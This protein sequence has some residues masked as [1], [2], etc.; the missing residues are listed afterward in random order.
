L[1]KKFDGIW[2]PDNNL[3]FQKCQDFSKNDDLFNSFK[4]DPIF[5]IV[6]GNDVRTKEISDICFDYIN[7]NH[8]YLFDKIIKFKEN[9]IYGSPNLY[10]Y[11]K[12]GKISP[13]TLY[14]MFILSRVIENFG[15]ISNFSICEIGSGYGGQAKIFMD[16]GIKKYT[17]ID[18]KDTLL[19]AKKYLG[20]FKYDNISY[21]QADSIEIEKYDLVIS[22]WCLSEL[23]DDGILFYIKN[24]IEKSK[25]SY[26]EMN[27]WD[28]TRKN[29]LIND[30]KKI[31]KNVN[32]Y[33]ELIKTSNNNNYTII[34]K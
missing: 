31:Y 23:D 29:K 33:P 22:N 10:E 1:K 27:M 32:V 19:L 12:I 8:N 24:I 25:Y 20:K 4:Q 34:C 6:I 7:D 18:M 2:I 9:D 13:G 3:F 16:Y 30:L 26:F 5:K 28:I 17:C 15:D 14:F 21:I 11:S